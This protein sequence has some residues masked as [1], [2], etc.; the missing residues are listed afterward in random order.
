M[1]FDV[2][3][4]DEAIAAEKATQKEIRDQVRSQ[5]PNHDRIQELEAE[6]KELKAEDRK[7]T[8]KEVRAHLKESRARVKELQGLKS[9]AESGSLADYVS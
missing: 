3:A 2:Q 5:G 4:I 9:A 6:L 1:E 8:G 7:A